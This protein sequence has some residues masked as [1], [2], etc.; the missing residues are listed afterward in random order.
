MGGGKGKG[1][2]EAEWWVVVTQFKYSIRKTFAIDFKTWCYGLS[3]SRGFADAI[4]KLSIRGDCN[5][6]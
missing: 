5:V 1:K 2:N 3:V 6:T 4:L